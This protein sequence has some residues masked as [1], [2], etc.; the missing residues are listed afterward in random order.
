MLNALA[1]V[2][3][4]LSYNRDTFADSLAMQQSQMYQEKNYHIAWIASVREEMRDF[5]TI[6]VGKL[7]N[8]GVLNTLL[9]GVS[10]GFL[11]E[12]QLDSEAPD[13]LAFA[14][15]SSLITSML[16][17]GCSILF[18]FIGVESAYAESRK[19]L[20][21]FVPDVHDAYNTDY[22]TKLLQWEGKGEA[23]RVPF[24]MEPRR[25]AEQK[26]KAGRAEHA[27]GK[28]DF[29][30]HFDGMMH[31]F[32]EP[33]QVEYLPKGD[34]THF[35]QGNIGTTTADSD[36]ERGKEIAQQEMNF[37]E[38]IGKYSL[39]WEPCSLASHDTM[40]LG[41]SA[42]CQSFSY[43]LFGFDM[44]RSVWDRVGM[45]I[46]MTIAG[47]AFA[48]Q[49]SRLLTSKA[50]L[51][52]EGQHDRGEERFCSGKMKHWVLRLL[53]MLGPAMV[54][55]G[56][57][58]ANGAVLLLGYALHGALP[59]YLAAFL[60]LSL[61]SL[62]QRRGLPPP[63]PEKLKRLRG[64]GFGGNKV[65]GDPGLE[66]RDSPEPMLRQLLFESEKKAIQTAVFMKR[67]LLKSYIVAILPWSWLA[68]G[69]WQSVPMAPASRD[70]EVDAAEVN[71]TWSSDAFF[72]AHAMSCSQDG[73]VWLASE[74]GVFQIASGADGGA[75]ES[76]DCPDLP[77]DESVRDITVRCSE[78]GCWPVVL[79]KSS[80]IYSC[81]P[82]PD[83]ALIPLTGLSG[84][85]GVAFAN[86][87]FYVRKNDRILH[88]PSRKSV[89]PPLPG[90][91]GFDILPNAEA[92]DV[93]LFSADKVARSTR[94]L[95][96]TWALPSK[97]PPLRAACAIDRSTMLAV[98]QDPSSE[99]HPRLL[100]FQLK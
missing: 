29:Y 85:S 68:V 8:T 56:V 96:Q 92:D 3:S 23:L 47:F 43:Y 72:S 64:K 70:S 71:L 93:F 97:M 17:F 21:K 73:R 31:D 98:V 16:Y 15:Y 69:A 39:L 12:G 80:R 54:M 13:S 46:T 59:V 30:E 74:D 32:N 7:Q 14:Y 45:H 53:M 58:C 89:A 28:D 5:L 82:E 4:G 1:V 87:G 75:V 40:V 48:G 76:V 44:G 90:L 62:P 83:E 57:L 6:F 38:I 78:S 9:F 77:V 60:F 24:V 20:L 2:I 99:N 11:C 22:I 63:H 26:S 10:T 84:V 55:T 35:R 66:A 51:E 79:G 86:E 81:H 95:L 67:L 33:T 61:R 100:L 18:C 50:E 36:E 91:V 34:N 27:S 25:L 37:N 41:V 49:L 19:F 52:L 42:L 65:E 94:A 88:I